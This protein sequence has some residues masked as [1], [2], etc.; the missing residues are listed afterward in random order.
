MF[1]IESG[2]DHAM[3]NFAAMIAQQV[4]QQA[5]KQ[6]ATQIAGQMAGQMMGQL[7]PLSMIQQL[8]SQLSQGGSAVEQGNIMR[9]LDQ[10]TGSRQ[11]TMDAIRDFNQGRMV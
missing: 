2:K 7:N 1:A 3:L 5:V 6:I 8:I 4:A 11:G 9:Q 10:E